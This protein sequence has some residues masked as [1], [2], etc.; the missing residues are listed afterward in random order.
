MN[1]GFV[2]TELAEPYVFFE[3]IL[4]IIVLGVIA[5]IAVYALLSKLSRMLDARLEAKYRPLFVSLINKHIFSN[6]EMYT[7]SFHLVSLPL[8]E[9][10][11]HNLAQKEVR[12]ILV[13]VIVDFHNKFPGDRARLLRKLY[14]D[15][16]FE[17]HAMVGLETLK[18]KQL[19]LVVEELIAMDIIVDESFMEKLKACKDLGVQAVASRYLSKVK[20][21]GV[22]ARS[23][24]YITSIGKREQA[25][26][27]H[28]LEN[29]AG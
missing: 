13:S 29:Q 21:V 6:E 27:I 17:L 18:G 4:A 5:G 23:D 25:K 28:L 3:N 12:K 16:D 22:K 15:L 10:R 20:G 9:F 24:E 11:K 1:Y 26:R 8:K 19:I 2:V 7:A 14:K